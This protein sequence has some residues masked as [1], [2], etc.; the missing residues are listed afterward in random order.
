MRRSYSIVSLCSLMTLVTLSICPSALAWILSSENVW[1]GWACVSVLPPFD[2]RLILVY[3]F[4]NQCP[5]APGDDFTYS[6]DLA[7]QIGS[8]WYHSHLSTQYC[9]GFRGVFI[10]YGQHFLTAASIVSILPSVDP[11]DP[12]KDLYDVDDGKSVL[13]VISTCQAVDLLDRKYYYYTRRLV[14]RLCPRRPE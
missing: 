12:L 6:F 2:L 13:D 8:Y 9:D 11:N 4:V 5:V 1:Y 3:S 10:V 14:S 7:D